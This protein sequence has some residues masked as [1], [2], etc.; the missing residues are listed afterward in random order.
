M[1]LTELLQIY[2]EQSN[3]KRIA[4]ALNTPSVKLHL[5]GIVGAADAFVAASVFQNHNNCH[6]LFIFSDKEKT[7]YFQNDLQNLLEKKTVELFPDSF[8][9]P[10]QFSEQNS[11]N[12]QLRTETLNRLANSVTGN[13]LIVT[14][15]EAIFEKVVNKAALRQSTILIR[16]ND[17]LNFDNITETLIG[18]GFELTDFVYEPGQF[19]VRG[20]ILD[21]FSFGNEWP[22]R[23]E[24][25]G[26]D[27]ESIRL[28]DPLSQLSQRKIS[29]VTIV[30]NI[31]TQFDSE[32]K[33]DLLK[34]LPENTVIWV[35]DVK[36]VLEKIKHCYESA[37]ELREHL[38]T[39]ARPDDE[40]IFVRHSPDEL[41]VDEENFKHDLEQFKILEFGKQ[42]YYQADNQFFFDC[43]PQ[44]SFNKNFNLLITDLKKHQKEGFE[45][46]IFSDNAKQIE[47]FYN[48]FDDLKAN[49]KFSPINIAI[50]EGFIDR[51]LKLVCY[52]D[53][54]IF[55][56]Y[57]KYQLRQ[58]F[59]KNK[60]ITLKAL[61]ELKQGDYVTHV[62]HGVGVYSG[63]EKIEVNGQMQEAVRI[64][65]RDNDMLY[66]NINSL[67]KISK[68]VGKEGTPPKI[69]KLGSD[70]WEALKRKAKSKVKDI[71]KDLIT[72][73]AKRKAAKGFAFTPDSYLQNELEA[74]FIYED[75]PDQLKATND[76][77]RDMESVHP[78]DRLVCGDVGF[79]KTE[80]AIRA[81]FKA[82]TDGKQAAVL[83]PTTILALQHYKTF[84]ERLKDFPVTVDYINRFKSAKEQ[85][86]TFKKLEEGKLD[87]VIGTHGLLS[88]KIKFKDLGI[89]I[90]DEE[91]KFGVASK[92]KLRQIKANVDTLTLTAT[93]IPRTL[94]FS[95]MAARDLSIINT[96]PPNRQP[97]DTE[98]LAFDTDRLKEVI[99]FEVYRRGQVFFIHN[100]VRDIYEVADM[101]KNIC[102][103]VDVSVAHGQMEGHD[104]EEVMINFIER[105]FDVLVCTN[106]VES[107]LDI[108]NANT[109]IINDAQNFG[110]SDLHQLRGRVG[111]SNK[112]A[113]CYLITPP[114]SVVSSDARKR[115]QTLEEFSE[116]GSG[117]QISMRD[118][119]IRGMGNLLGAEQSGYIADIGF[120]MYHKI[121]DE[122]IQELKETDFRDVFADDLLRDQKFVKDCQVELD[123][124]M[125]IPD[126][127]VISVAERL[128]L[129][130]ELNNMTDEAGILQFSEKL[131]DR[132]GPLPEEVVRLFD[133]IRLQWAGKKLGFE[134]IVLKSDW[135]R[136][137]FTSNQ[138]STYFN[139][140]QFTYIINYIQ[141]HPQSCRMKQTEKN[142]I[143]TISPVNDVHHAKELLQ[144]LVKEPALETV[145]VKAKN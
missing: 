121:L 117:F 45:V 113:F 129:Y 136:C 42:F 87:I 142:L 78:M 70:A 5:A 90:I 112:K 105:K 88:G 103:N 72:L 32:E 126:E 97:I 83:V 16:I 44:P 7:A 61:R 124:E 30:P 11:A 116:L 91:Q 52:T 135:M 50:R 66:V 2:R 86:E 134:R 92:E 55:E 20:G 108:A 79:G 64:I 6:H 48:I 110:L 67:H 41:F 98:L 10:G 114:F 9:K 43:Y 104:L 128:S 106:I 74:S 17:K 22:Y 138:E 24:L 37:V 143:L 111:R 118:L 63:L 141:K 109:I 35:E 107:G 71:A 89:L 144:K 133:A 27:V 95:L 93:P 14:Y 3:A 125:L 127:Y 140:E 47:R 81:A 102:P 19:A 28:F 29:Q 33:I 57:H 115:L 36:V 15:P 82:A 1:D 130:T 85:K 75:T 54:Q 60:A 119:D 123:E 58:G 26:N 132:F 139:S 18:Y 25:F 145:A 53:H 99:E 4:G 40:N 77:K 38:I 76:V 69:N 84:K 51:D 59:S 12:I 73:Y 49:I 21:I 96:P 23:V 131:V 68:Y 46:L 122:A 137:Y 101:I 62:D 13:E 39:G 8:K 80:V 100:R 120:D 31:Q 65:Y 56:R 94:Q 34:F